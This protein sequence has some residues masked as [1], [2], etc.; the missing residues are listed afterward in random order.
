MKNFDKTKFKIK[1]IDKFSMPK[2]NKIKKKNSVDIENTSN[3]HPNFDITVSQISSVN[4]TSANY[5]VES[6][7]YSKK[8]PSNSQTKVEENS[9][10]K[11][12]RFGLDIKQTEMNIKK[13]ILNEVEYKKS[14][15]SNSPS[16]KT[17]YLNNR[18]SSLSEETRK[19]YEN[20]SSEAVKNLLAK[21]ILK[22]SNYNNTNHANDKVNLTRLTRNTKM[23][24]KFN[25]FTQNYLEKK[26][27]E[28]YEYLKEC[29]F[30]PN[31]TSNRLNSSHN[32]SVIIENFIKKQENYSK[33]KSLIKLQNNSFTNRE[34]NECTFQPKVN[35]VPN[36]LF[37]KSNVENILTNVTNSP[38]KS[39]LTYSK[40]L[41][42]I[43]Q[44]L[45]ENQSNQNCNNSNSKIR[46]N[47]LCCSKSND[48]VHNIS[49][50]VINTEK[51][52]FVDKKQS[53]K[54]NSEFLLKQ[55]GTEK[56]DKYDTNSSE[57]RNIYDSFSKD[58]TN[59]NK[60][61]KYIKSKV[62]IETSIFDKL[63][64]TKINHFKDNEVRFKKNS[65]ALIGNKIENDKFIKPLRDKLFNINLDTSF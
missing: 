62:D 15:N 13:K 59:D 8:H 25:K 55:L 47:K 36:N 41:D 53:V 24:N 43:K 11:T 17:A 21:V 27:F 65:Y 63:Y 6:S 30:Q 33:N 60:V 42:K 51:I 26:S 20:S 22:N 1:K 40:N 31:Y 28:E 45:K 50:Q 9:N 10:L 37:Y 32:K 38:N 56:I 19:F 48:V 34:F 61:K 64:K 23:T 49:N 52:S 39:V 44:K 18:E 54:D 57:R 14:R 4:S 16:I 29:T 35:P 58:N 2:T 3:K 5:A 7:V 12:A 46:K